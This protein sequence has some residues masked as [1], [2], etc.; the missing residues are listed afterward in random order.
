MKTETPPQEFLTRRQ[1]MWQAAAVGGALATPVSMF[2]QAAPVASGDVVETTELLRGWSLKSMEPQADLPA[3][4]LSQAGRAVT[5]D[6]WLRVAAMPALAHDIL[7]A[8]DPS[9]CFFEDDYFDL[10]PGETK[11]VRILGPHPRGRIALITAKPWY[12]PHKTAFDW[13]TKR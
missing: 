8:H 12:S 7:L 9:G 10:L 3:E 11:T 6:G 13:E 1:F 2:G 4:F 5:G